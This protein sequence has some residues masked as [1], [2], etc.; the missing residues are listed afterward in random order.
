MRTSLFAAAVLATTLIASSSFAALLTTT[1]GDK[2]ING[3]KIAKDGQVNINGQQIPVELIG[4]GLRAKRVVIANVKVYV[5]ELLSSDASKFVRTDADALSSL[6]QSRTIALRLT[7]LRGVD[8]ATVQ[9]SYKEA[10]DAN[11]ISTSDAAIA[12]FLQAVTAGGDADNG[13]AMTIVTNKEANGDETVY[14]EGTKDGAPAKITGPKGFS[15]KLMAIWLGTPADS[16]LANL[17]TQ[18]IKGM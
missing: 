3:V 7:F 13:K 6:D 14:Y 5:A 8:A 4:A 16:G 12:Q 2:V 17:K 18:L 9:T 1:P 10:L 15:N 11:K